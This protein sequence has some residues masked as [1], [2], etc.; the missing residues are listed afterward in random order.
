MV[1]PGVLIVRR[2]FAYTV[3]ALMVSA[4]V[5]GQRA[6]AQEL[7]NASLTFEQFLAEANP[8]AQQL[9]GDV[10]RVGQARYLLALASVASRLSDAPLP[11]SMNDTTQGET[12]G[13]FIGFNP[14]GDPFTVL[15]WRLEP[16]AR[17]RPHAH[18]YGNVVTLGLEGEAYCE[19]FETL[20]QRDFTTTEPFEVRRTQ[21]QILGPGSINLVNLERDYIHGSVGGPRGA[22]GLDITTRLRTREPTP[23]LMIPP[24]TDR[25]RVFQANWSLDDPRPEGR[26][27]M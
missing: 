4:S 12:P 7:T 1:E 21:A 27:A 16:G 9:K 5:G 11:A 13:T 24:G 8:L 26:G 3:A 14:G 15:H 17:I 19:N 22:R 20:R 10:T 23:Y 6:Q 2:T 25:S 18:T